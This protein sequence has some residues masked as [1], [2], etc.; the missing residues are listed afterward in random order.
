MTAIVRKKT[1]RGTFY[2]RVAAIVIFALLALISIQMAGM[3]N[4]SSVDST[5]ASYYNPSSHIQRDARLPQWPKHPV[6]K[7]TD[8]ILVVYSGP[9]H[10]PNFKI[11]NQPEPHPRKKIE[12]KKELYRVNFEYF[13]INGV[14]CQT[15]DTVLIVTKE[16]EEHY[17]E[18]ID[19]MHQTCEETHGHKVILAVRD[20]KCFDLET[21]RRVMH[22]DIV[23]IDSYDY[24]VYV[25]CGTSGP[26]KYWADLPWTDVL[27]DK[28]NDKVKMS[29]LTVNCAARHPH[30]QSMVYALDR[31]G[32]QLIKNS[33]AIFDCSKRSEY[34]NTTKY[35]VRNYEFK[36]GA[37][38][39]KH[40]YGLSGILN[41]GIVD[42]SNTKD[43]INDDHYADMWV[44][45]RMMKYFGRII[46]LDEAVFFKTS[47]LTTSETAMEINYN[48]QVDWNW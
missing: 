39:L 43:C 33:T 13:L 44:T 36:M 1:G 32:L 30:V 3:A 19:K 24:F 5:K 41:P 20:P 7:A 14:Q 27:I 48:Y 40:G 22:D 4:D 46:S 42:S 23:D 16:V 6:T 47:R 17:R 28:L 29:G 11:L 2:K 25:N 21:V 38:L 18:R 45:H 12:G 34:D 31:V 15:Q 35:I 8:K 26:S 37:L 9:T 10:L